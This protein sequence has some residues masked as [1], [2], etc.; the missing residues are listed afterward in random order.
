LVNFINIFKREF[1]DFLSEIISHDIIPNFYILSY[2]EQVK[3]LKELNLIDK[4]IEYETLIL[5]TLNK[6]VLKLPDDIEKLNTYKNDISDINNNMFSENI[7]SN[8]VLPIIS[9][10]RESDKIKTLLALKI[11]TKTESGIK[12]LNNILDSEIIFFG[13]NK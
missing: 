1:Y 7:I 13:Y 9:S 11:N 12:Y 10:S 2:I 8:Y 4:I 5:E 6:I 3:L